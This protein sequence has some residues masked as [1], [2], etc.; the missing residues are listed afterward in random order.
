MAG[1]R[2]GTKNNSDKAPTRELF[3]DD[4]TQAE[5]QTTRAPEPEKRHAG[6]HPYLDRRP[7]KFINVPVGGFFILNGD[8]WQKI[9]S[10]RGQHF[11]KIPGHE[12]AISGGIANFSPGDYVFLIDT[13]ED[14]RP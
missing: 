10:N 13:T 8:S 7:V 6:T 14:T 5:T 3:S 9:D 2:K 4:V 1:R 11:I 12:A